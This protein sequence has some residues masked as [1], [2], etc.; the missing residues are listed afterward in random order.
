MLPAVGFFDDVP[1]PPLFEEPPEYRSP[2]WVAPPDNTA[3]SSTD[4]Q[5]LLVHQPDLAVLAYGFVA[6][7]TGVQLRLDIRGAL[8]VEDPELFC[9]RHR[10][11][12]KGPSPSE[13]FR[14][15]VELSDGSKVTGL[16]PMGRPGERPSGPVLVVGSG[17][18]G[19][20]RW[21]FGYWLWPLPPAGP[22]AMVVEWRAQEVPETRTVLDAGVLRAAASKAVE[23][24]PDERPEPPHRSVLGD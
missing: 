16:G 11:R 13:T 8:D 10:R 15:G 21:D 4:L 23:L 20:R 24:W 22:L 17:G 5:A 3:G 9:F 1:E 7:P 2:P 6:Y 14:F 18:G 12:G 19:G